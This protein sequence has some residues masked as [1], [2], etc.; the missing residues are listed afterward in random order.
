M[1]IPIGF[2]RL[3]QNI[4]FFCCRTRLDLLPFFARLVATINLV[5]HDVAVDLA[6]KLKSEFKFLISKKNQLNIESK[7]EFLLIPFFH[8]IQFFF[9]AS[10]SSQSG[11]LHRRN[12]EIRPLSQNRSVV[13]P[14]NPIARIPAS[15]DRDD[16]RISRSGRSIFVQLQREPIPDQR[17]LGTNDAP[18]NGV[19]TG[20]ASRGPN[21]E[22]VLFG[23]TAG[24]CDNGEKDP[25]ANAHVHSVFDL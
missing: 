7:S 22:L 1:R 13:L 18:E 23:E 14:E 2:F 19:R 12:D 6:Q 10:I 16:V 17:L 25:T 3:A 20:I 8:Y 24:R 15:P 9:S 11:S 5:S 21:R 4:F